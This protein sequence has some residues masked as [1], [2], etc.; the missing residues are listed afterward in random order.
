MDKEITMRFLRLPLMFMLLALAGLAITGCQTHDDTA[1]TAGQPGPNGPGGPSTPGF[2]NDPSQLFTIVSVKP[3][4]GTL[5]TATGKWSD[6][7]VTSNVEV[8]F[9]HAPAKASLTPNVIGFADAAGSQVASTVTISNNTATFDP[10]ADLTAG[11]HYTFYIQADGATYGP[12]AAECDKAG[13]TPKYLTILDA[14]GNPSTDPDPHNN[15]P[16]DTTPAGVALAVTGTVPKD[17][18]NAGTDITPKI[19]FNQPVDTNSVPANCTPAITLKDTT[20]SVPVSGSCSVSTDGNSVTFTPSTPLTSGDD[21]TLTTNINGSGGIAAKDP[22]AATTSST[23][24]INFTADD[25]LNTKD[26]TVPLAGQSN[27]PGD[28]VCLLGANGKGGLV[29]TLFAASGPLAPLAANLPA[30]KMLKT[31][32][33]ALLKNDD[34]SL[35]SLV[36]ALT[37]GGNLQNGIQ[38]LLMNKDTGLAAI[39]QSVVDPDNLKGLLGTDG[40]VADLLKTLATGTSNADCQSALGTVCLVGNGGQHG[41][42]DMLL[43]DSGYLTQEGINTGTLVSTLGNML[44]NNGSLASTVQ[45]LFQQGHLQKGLQTLLAGDKDNGTPGLLQTLGGTLTSLPGALSGLVGGLLGGV[46]LIP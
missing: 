10:T 32:L 8:T 6:V 38:T 1:P 23:D 36:T 4:T 33:T 13:T 28:G 11:A 40:G 17:G 7:S 37:T 39:V 43:G 46:G 30:T 44:Q 19:T 9:N 21:Y 18:G 45:G 5:D 14:S 31:D 12:R 22:S 24:T 34:G 20:S 2:C 35:Q 3:T 25:L 27:V 41:V 29:D 16:I 42:L 15:T 26:C